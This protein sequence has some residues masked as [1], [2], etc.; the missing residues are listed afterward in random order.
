M[1]KSIDTVVLTVR[2]CSLCVNVFGAVILSYSSWLIPK[3]LANAFS[4]RYLTW[5]H[6]WFNKNSSI[7]LCPLYFP[8]FLA[9]AMVTLI[10]QRKL[11]SQYFCCCCAIIIKP[12]NPYDMHSNTKLSLPEQS[13]RMAMSMVMVAH[14]FRLCSFLVLVTL[15]MSRQAHLICI[16]SGFHI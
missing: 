14:V 9:A 16:V 15:S 11:L 3:C 13:I 10:H 12:I 6:N 1:I 8:F 4:C 2:I 5:L 7:K